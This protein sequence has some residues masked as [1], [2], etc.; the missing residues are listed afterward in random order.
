MSKPEQRSLVA[1]LIVWIAAS[2]CLPS[3]SLPAST[4][5]RDPEYVITRWTTQDGLPESSATSAVQTPEGYLWFGSFNGLVRFDGVKFTVLNPTNTVQPL[6]SRKQI[7]LTWTVDNSI[8][9]DVQAD[10]P[11]Q[12]NPS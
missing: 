2:A 8:P 12:A 1:S 9:A 11:A 3:A 7:G 6:A 4:L 10:S 5:I